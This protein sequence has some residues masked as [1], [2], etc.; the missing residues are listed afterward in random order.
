MNKTE[1]I[2]AAIQPSLPVLE[3][4]LNQREPYHER[5]WRQAADEEAGLAEVRWLVD[6]H[7][8]FL[9]RRQILAIS[10]DEQRVRRRRVL[11]AT[12]AWGYGK[13]GLRFRGTDPVVS[14]LRDP[15]LDTRL[16][17]CA[18]SLETANA[19]S[20]YRAMRGIPYFKAAF[21]TKYLYFQ[22]K[23]L[24]PSGSY[25][26]ILDSMVSASLA[27]LT[28]YALYVEPAAWSSDAEGNA[29][30]FQRYVTDMHQWADQLN[31]AA[32]VLEFFFWAGTSRRELREV[33]QKVHGGK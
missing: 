31:V 25:P 29:E 23:Q 28:G 17:E 18:V 9:T 14:M 11:V 2:L 21:F 24:N 20:A 33:C 13:T 3:N 10:H 7:D 12:A 19:S 16:E 8:G 1:L 22:G 4:V 30:G 15:A 6:E 27:W 26:L 32:D 5:L